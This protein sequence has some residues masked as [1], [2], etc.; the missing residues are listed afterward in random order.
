MIDWLP[1][2]EVAKVDRTTATAE[3]ARSL[4]YVGLEHIEASSG[5]FIEGY[6]SVAGDVKATKFLFTPKHVLYGKLR[7]YLNKRL[8]PTFDGVCS[9]E[10]LPVLPKEGKLDRYYLFHYLGTKRFVDWASDNV[11]GAN[12]PRL[13]PALLNEAL[14]PHRPL[15]EQQAIAQQLERADRLRRLRQHALTISDQY[16][17]NVFLEMFGDP[18]T[19]P[20]GWDRAEIAEVIAS[21]QYGTSQKSNTDGLGYPVIG[22][23]HITYSGRMDVVDFNH[24]ELDQADF[25]DLAL[26]QGDILFNRTNS[27]ELVGKTAV[28]NLDLQAV[29]ASYLIRIKLKDSVTP[30][31]FAALLNTP[32]FKRTFVDRCKRAV[33]QSNVSPTLLKEFVMY[34]PPRP[35]Q[36]SFTTVV[37]KHERLRRMQVEALRQ[38]EQ[39][40][41]TLL[42]EAFGNQS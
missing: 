21:S 27:T 9:T 7:P 35:L 6:S 42:E 39:L 2:E 32:H 13:S 28:W 8:R 29:P 3:Q 23:N 37:Q 20:K 5:V 30:E 26:Q 17:Q 12:L 15:P 14:L 18:E 1:L 34:V 16:L 4:P 11:S 40:Y 41:E 22:M 24:V 10:I 25:D 38:A 36:D 19:N 31:F 33:S